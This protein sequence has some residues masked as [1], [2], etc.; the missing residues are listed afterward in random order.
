VNHRGGARKHGGVI[1]L[2]IAAIGVRRQNGGAARSV[3]RISAGGITARRM[4]RAHAAQSISRQP[5]K[6]KKNSEASMAKENQ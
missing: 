2:G 3:Q 6:K 1:N 5:K 4:A